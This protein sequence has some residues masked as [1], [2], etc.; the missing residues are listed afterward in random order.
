MAG[1][2]KKFFGNLSL[3][4]IKK[5]VLELPGK[6]DNNEKYGKQLKVQAA[7]WEDG[8]ISI[9][10][11]DGENKVSIPLGNLR[12]SKFDDNASSF[13]APATKELPEGDLP[14]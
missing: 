4:G 8:G 10:L 3:D 7:Q 1:P 11:W 5:A 2:V 12:V 14:F 13:S 6:V 9:S